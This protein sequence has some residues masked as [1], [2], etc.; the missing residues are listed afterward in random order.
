[1]IIRNLQEGLFKFNYYL[2]RQINEYTYK[3]KYD[4]MS[5]YR[6]F[7]IL[8]VEDAVHHYIGAYINDKAIVAKSNKS[9]LFEPN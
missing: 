8:P 4:D 1:M 9:V 2:E 6:G 7:D 5:K 3:S